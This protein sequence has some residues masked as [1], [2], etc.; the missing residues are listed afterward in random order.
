VGCHITPTLDE[1]GALNFELDRRKADATFR[2]EKCHI[3][4]AAAP[5]P[6]SHTSATTGQAAH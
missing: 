4:L 2:C 1:G 5:V 3:A 6:A